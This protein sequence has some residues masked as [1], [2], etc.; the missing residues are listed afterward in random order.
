[1]TIGRFIALWTHPDCAPDHVSEQELEDT[2]RRFRT[3]LPA[4][5]RNAVLQFGLPRPT[6]E[7][8]DA[9]VD[10]ELDLRDVSDF[11]SPSEIVSVTEDWRD[12]GL[13]EE[14]VA[15]A[16]D[17]VGNLFCFPTEAE[18]GGELPVFFFNHDNRTAD[19]IAL[20]FTQWIEEF[21]RVAPH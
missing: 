16:T 4:D 2:E 17:C 9:I 11:L 14:F 18:A 8:L 13:P 15:F 7:L 6:A 10:R 5:Y 3:R 21:C 12:L 20:T 19:V 1:M